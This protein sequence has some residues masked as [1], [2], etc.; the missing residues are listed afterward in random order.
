LV[1]FASTALIL[2]SVDSAEAQSSGVPTSNGTAASSPSTKA[3]KKAQR[4]IAR[5]EARAK[6]TAELK[7]LEDN[8]YQP[9][10]NDPNYPQNLQNAEKKAKQGAQ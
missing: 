10:V 8:G 1:L 2:S 3:E 5:K 6:N 9:H 7:R 4:K